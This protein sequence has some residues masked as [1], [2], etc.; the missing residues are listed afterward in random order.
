M[1][2]VDNNRTYRIDDILFDK[3]PRD[4]FDSADGREISYIDYYKVQLIHIENDCFVPM[5]CLLFISFQK[6]G[7]T[8]KDLNQ[9][10]L[11]SHLK[12]KDVRAG[13]KK[14]IFL[15]PELC[16]ATGLTDDMR[17]NFR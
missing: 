2:I 9:P 1:I 13:Q 7:K 3:S 15:I 10:L 11:V 17:S 14:D 5:W 16:R 8:I 12:E 6:Y 4:T